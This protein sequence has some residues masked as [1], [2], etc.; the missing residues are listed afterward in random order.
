MLQTFSSQRDIIIMYDNFF[1]EYISL[2]NLSQNRRGNFSIVSI[3]EY[4][5]YTDF[6]NLKLG[7]NKF[8]IDSF[9]RKYSYFKEGKSLRALS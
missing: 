6:L 4:F 3:L 8:Y 5:P 9:L 7:I 1:M 2:L